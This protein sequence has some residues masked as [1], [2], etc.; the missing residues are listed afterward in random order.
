VAIVKAG[1]ISQ[2]VNSEVDPEEFAISYITIYEGGNFLSKVYND[3]SYRI[4]ALEQ[5]KCK[6][7]DEIEK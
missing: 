4:K 6:I 2:D 5:I 7:K 3:K 1:I